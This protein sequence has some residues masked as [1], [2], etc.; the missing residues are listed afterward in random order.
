MKFERWNIA[1]HAP[2]VEALLQASG[3]P[4]LAAA[5]LSSRGI[6]TI[7]Q[8]KAFLDDGTHL[9][10]D[11]LA[12]RDMQQAVERIKSAISA[13]EHMVI[14]GDYDVDGI[15]A[16]C[17]M[18]RY[19]SDLGANCTYYIPDRLEEGYGLNRNAITF[20][21]KQGV[22]LL[23]TVDCG[24][25]AIEEVQYAKECGIDVIITDHHECKDKLPDAQAVVNPH[26]KDCTYPFLHL[27]GVGVALKLALA[28]T[29]ENQLRK[30][31]Q[32]LAPL[33]AV[34]TVADVMPLVGENRA[35]LQAGLKA[36]RLEMDN[37]TKPER[38]GL[39]MLI[40]EA[41]LEKRGID[42]TGI[43]FVLAP[44]IN[45]AGRMG[46]AKLA[47]E[48]L[49]TED[50]T[51]AN[52]L[53][54]QL[55][56]LNRERQSIEMTIY[57]QALS[58]IQAMQP[59]E[60]MAL[61]LE[62]ARWHQGVVGIVAS[63]L[64]D[65]YACPVFMICLEGE[66]GKGSCRSYG[67]LNLF[68]ALEENQD[69]LE[70]FGGHALAAGFTI[71]K[72]NIPALRFRLNAYVCRRWGAQKP[73]SELAIDVE[74]H[75]PELLT[76]EQVR[77]LSILEP[78]GAGNPKPLFCMRGFT[79]TTLSHVG[80]GRHLKLRL[81][82][83]DRQFD[84][85]FFSTNAKETGV[86]LGQRVDAA[87]TLQINEFRGNQTVQLILVDLH[88]ACTQAQMQKALYQKYKNKIP[89]TS[90]ETKV[91]TP[92]RE[93]FAAVWRYLLRYAGTLGL[94]DTLPSLSCKIAK[95]Y[96]LPAT[97]MRTM[98]CLEVFAERGL[99][100]LQKDCNRL[101]IAIS[102]KIKKV[103]LEQSPIMIALRCNRKE[104]SQDPL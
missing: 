57:E 62:D 14:Y 47:V 30:V 25:T 79:I 21:A 20:L 68:E 45:A 71:L 86:R 89:F 51:H 59:E 13:G 6:Q 60:C 56:Q 76:T 11:P 40:Q 85:I 63:R 77:A 67:G 39:H 95:T 43:G 91:I 23:V 82:K 2:V 3:M 16:T 31:F 50:K 15:T 42:S 35:I 5:V 9:L 26:R 22:T 12:L 18:V 74:L 81:K 10:Q 93:D 33:A 1:S 8:A 4:P 98:V 53:A 90:E 88:P 100:T 55:C 96:G 94:E 41:G 52:L 99:I 24:I 83:R 75:D 92:D 65:R 66:K 32:T 49:L 103:D 28:L 104:N 38:T 80:D 17:L 97:V 72:K 34:G 58:R 27:A 48:L 7:E 29:P 19:L 78:H 37:H 87:F 36:I 64:A 46:C 70:S 84:A 102:T 101:R 54:K 73:V 61:V 69:L 44:R